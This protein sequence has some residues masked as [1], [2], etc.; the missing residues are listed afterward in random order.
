MDE[1][2]GLLDCSET[3]SPDLSEEKTRDD[4]EQPVVQAAFQQA[5]PA[6]AQVGVAGGPLCAFIVLCVHVLYAWSMTY[7]AKLPNN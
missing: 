5:L 2:T 1:E 6:A 7:T 3:A 4:T